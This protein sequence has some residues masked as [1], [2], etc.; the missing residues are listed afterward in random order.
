MGQGA[1]LELDEHGW[2]KRLEPNC[3]VE[4][5]LNTIEGGHYPGEIIRYCMRG[6]G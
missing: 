3:W 4:T 1:G 2:V 5:P 6:R